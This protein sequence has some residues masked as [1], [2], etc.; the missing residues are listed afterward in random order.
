MHQVPL[1]QAQ[2]LLQLRGV[3]FDLP[4]A[5]VHHQ[6]GHTLPEGHIDHVL[7]PVASLDLC[8]HQR[9]VFHSQD[10]EL[11]GQGSGPQVQAAQGL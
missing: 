4:Y 5:A 11:Q 7:L 3:Y 1:Q 6:C 9:H 10:H 8:E 2:P